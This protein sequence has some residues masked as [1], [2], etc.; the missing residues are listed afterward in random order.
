MSTLNMKVGIPT[1]N[2]RISPVLDVAE[3]LLVIDIQEGRETERKEI[4]LLDGAIEKR[5][6]DIAALGLDVLICG[7]V[8]IPLE[9]ILVASGIQVVCQ[10]CGSV[11]EVLQA[12]LDGRLAQG[13][14]LAPGCCGQRR[15]FRGQHGCRRLNS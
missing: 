6:A 14:F 10:T 3:R 4:A 15:R 5:G 13:G 11:E 8:S 9:S 1:W 7:A 2:G 12:F